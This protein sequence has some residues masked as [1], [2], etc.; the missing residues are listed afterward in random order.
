MPDTPLHLCPLCGYTFDAAAMDC[1][2]SC[3]MSAGCHVICCPNCGYQA[4]DEYQMVIASTLKRIW[5]SL[6]LASSPPLSDF[7]SP[8]TERG[9][10][11]EAL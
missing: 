3:P 5:D 6:G 9:A 7:P 8:Y 10:G 1:H 11:G 4:P 2:T